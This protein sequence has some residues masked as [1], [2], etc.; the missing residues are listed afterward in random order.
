V[1]VGRAAELAVDWVFCPWLGAPARRPRR[2]EALDLVA[3]VADG[4]SVLPRVARVRTT[5][6]SS[7][8][9]LRPGK[10]ATG[11]ASRIMSP[12]KQLR[13]RLLR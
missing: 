7:Q 10:S 13:E 4:L 2:S 5:S 6:F 8:G 3:G 11:I 1:Y 12:W 9:F